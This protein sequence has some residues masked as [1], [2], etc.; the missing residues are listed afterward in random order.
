MPIRKKGD[1]TKKY[2]S[3]PIAKDEVQYNKIL[4]LR[5]EAKKIIKDIYSKKKKKKQY[6]RDLQ[7]RDKLQPSRSMTIDTTTSLYGDAGKG[8]PAPKFSKGGV[9]RGTGIAVK[10]KNFKGV[11]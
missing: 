7:S 2:A 10:G 5:K 8:R 6:D 11:F 4:K 1:D 3:G 9:C